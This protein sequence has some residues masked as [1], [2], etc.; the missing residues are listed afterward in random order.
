[1][2]CG[3]SGFGQDWCDMHPVKRGLFKKRQNKHNIFIYLHR[4]EVRTNLQNKKRTK[5]ILKCFYFE[6]FDKE[7]S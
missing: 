1:M 7:L 2:I 3:D 4:T 6:I 5:N